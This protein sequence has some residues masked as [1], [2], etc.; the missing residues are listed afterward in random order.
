[1]AIS[2]LVSLMA[3]CAFATPYGVCCREPKELERSGGTNYAGN[4]L[5][6]QLVKH[7]LGSYL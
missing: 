2:F 4:N 6:W 5:I 3:L 7:K 1:M